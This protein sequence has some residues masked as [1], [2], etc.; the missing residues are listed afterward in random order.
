MPEIVI[1]GDWTGFTLSFDAFIFVP[2]IDVS[3]FAILLADVYTASQARYATT[4]NVPL[5]NGT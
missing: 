5:F 3:I 1:R 2:F 4:S